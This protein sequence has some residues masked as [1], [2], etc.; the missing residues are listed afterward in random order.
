MGIIL[1][2]KQSCQL[3]IIFR[4]SSS[5]LNL[6]LNQFQLEVWASTLCKPLV[7]YSTEYALN[8]FVCLSGSCVYGRFAHAQ[9]PPRKSNSRLNR[10]SRLRACAVETKRNYCACAILIRPF[11]F[12]IELFSSKNKRQ[13]PDSNPR[14]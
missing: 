4:C 12:L 5:D 9:N 13:R 7:E 2:I 6:S 11:P 3:F 8:I 10:K 14:P 1:Y